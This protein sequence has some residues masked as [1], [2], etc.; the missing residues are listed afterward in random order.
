M[1]TVLILGKGFIGQGLAK[2]LKG[3]N[4]SV[5]F[6]SRA[7][8]DYTDPLT[9]QQFLKD[10]YNNIEVVINCS[11]FTGR[12]NV[13]GCEDHKAE[14]WFRNVIVPRNI[15]LSSNM[16][17]LPVFQVNSGC[18]YTGYEKEY[19][20]LDEPNFGLFEND[21]SFYSKTKHA[22]ETIFKNCLVYSLRIRMPFE[23][24][25]DKKNYLYKL[26]KYNDLISM[27]NSLTSTEDLYSF[28]LKFIV[29]RRTLAPGPINVVNGGSISAKEIIEIFK[30]KN[31]NN[32]RWNFIE[33]DSLNTKAKRSNCILSTDK[34][35]AVNL[36]LPDTRA[37]L[38]RDI[39]T[40]A[41]LL[42]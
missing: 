28:I 34:L 27:P 15:V 20:E 1:K 39:S 8:L 26:Y 30:L 40:F 31:I 4:I 6:Y 25:L 18:I 22:C 35:K 19:S 17:E 9:L 7:E 42:Q 23:G 13:D 24:S 5:E 12:P 32:P 37:S 41:S 29:L 38:E 36:Q 33:L 21:S 14:C 10:K 11:G 3:R 16:F 2:Y